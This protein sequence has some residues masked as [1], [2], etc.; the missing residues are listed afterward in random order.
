MLKADFDSYVL[1]FEGAA[2][3]CGCVLWKISGWKVVTVQSFVL[4]DVTVNDAE[5]HGLLEGLVMVAERNI[6]DVIV[7]G[8]PRIVIQQVQGPINCNQPK[9]QQRLAEYGRN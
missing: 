8:D 5:N 7:V 1:R 6:P 2:K 3:T 4:E 9:L